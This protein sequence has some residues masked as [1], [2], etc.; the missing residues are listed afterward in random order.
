ME[1]R[2]TDID[3]VPTFWLESEE[4]PRGEL[5]ACLM[6]R[7][8]RA[9]ETLAYGGITHMLEHLALY[10]LGGRAEQ[11]HNGQVEPVVTKFMVHGGDE[12][13]VKFFGDVCGG[14]ADL[15]L[16]R[17]EDER[18]V[19]RTEAES[20]SS[21]VADP[22]LTWRYGAATYGLPGFRELGLRHLGADDLVRW[23][24]RWF[25]AGNAVLLFAG[26][27][28]PAGLR[29][30]L[31]PGE[32]ISPPEPS[33]ALAWLP[34]YFNESVNG[35]G[36]QTVL[37]RSTAAT[38]Y[39]RILER[40]IYTVLRHEHGLTYGPQAAY[41]PRDGQFA[42]VTAFADGVPESHEKLV[43]LFVEQMERLAEGGVDHGE[44]TECVRHVIEP[45]SEPEWANAH[46][47]ASAWD[48]LMGRPGRATPSE[49]R[50]EHQELTPGA[51]QD[52]A[53]AALANALFMLPPGQRL[54]A[55][56]YAPV[57]A[58]SPDAV[59]GT[60]YEPVDAS[61]PAALVVGD[62]GVGLVDGV[63]NYTV[64][65]H[66]CVAMLAWPDGARRLVGRDAVQVEVEPTVWRMD[67]AEV[68]R[69]DAGVPSGAVVPMPERDPE[70]IPRPSVTT[71]PPSPQTDD[72]GLF[73]LFGVD[74]LPP[75][76]RWYALAAMIA[77]LAAVLFT[78]S[79]LGHRMVAITLFAVLYVAR[80]IVV[81]RRKKRS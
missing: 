74:R 17:I 62:E 68:A 2:E 18:R 54:S 6:F 28:P 59:P 50:K 45:M 77:G 70:A 73:S 23:R 3:G 49:L 66:D 53:S 81:E 63:V 69:I 48:T 76:M 4:Q 31:P 5:R 24:D 79:L 65:Y 36:M 71:P 25:T 35:V 58:G 7:V 75:P 44:L 64:R 22:L 40:R 1:L 27:P 67:R 10:R 43:P 60:R 38:M 13:V 20:R 72:N 41:D 80:L 9:D 15:P 16:F 47:Y 34:T 52:V 12:E 46:L 51:I 29:L 42:H 39:A 11:H 19:L 33:D 78:L 57:L 21:S 32:R 61:S 30:D 55:V 56:K 14:L 8:G 37:R 26:G